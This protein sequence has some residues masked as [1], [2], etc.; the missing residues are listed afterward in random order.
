MGP[1]V[2]LEVVECVKDGPFAF[3]ESHCSPVRWGLIALPVSLAGLWLL[4]K[5]NL[6]KGD[7]RTSEV[8]MEKALVA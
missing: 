6:G 4:L 3:L 5:E 1:W 7:F 8:R 2:H